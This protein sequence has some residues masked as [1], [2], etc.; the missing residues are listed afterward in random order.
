MSPNVCVIHEAARVL[1]GKFR[2]EEGSVSLGGFGTLTSEHQRVGRGLDLTVEEMEIENNTEWSSVF[3][4]EWDETP[5]RNAAHFEPPSL[6]DSILLSEPDNLPVN[7]TIPEKQENEKENQ[8]QKKKKKM[9]IRVV[10]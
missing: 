9:H 1:G 10:R 8:K 5:E 6:L 4:I 2:F 7:A 3:T